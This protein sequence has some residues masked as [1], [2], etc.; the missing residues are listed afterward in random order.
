MDDF[1]SQQYLEYKGVSPPGA[2][3]NS[4]DVAKTADYFMSES[5]L[6]GHK[7]VVYFQC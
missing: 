2:A 7:D 1:Q 5:L 3:Q 4:I 6:S